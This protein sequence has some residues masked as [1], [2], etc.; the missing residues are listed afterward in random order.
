VN[1]VKAALLVA[2]HVVVILVGLTAGLLLLLLARI[3]SATALLILTRTLRL[4][5]LLLLTGLVLPTLLGVLLLLTI[6]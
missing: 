5:A 1:F 4:V 2:I 6:H 3:A